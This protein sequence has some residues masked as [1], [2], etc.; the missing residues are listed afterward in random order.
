MSHAGLVD[1]FLRVFELSRVIPGE[2]AAIVTDGPTPGPYVEIAHD[3]F[4][5]MGIP[6]FHLDLTGTAD[7]DESIGAAATVGD[8][9]SAHPGVIAALRGCDFVLDLLTTR[10]GGLIHDRSRGLVADSGTR[11]LH[12]NEP[13]E[14]LLR[15]V[16]TVG[17]RDQ[18]LRAAQRLREGRELH[19]S[20]ATGTDLSVD[21]TGS[22]VNA[23]YGYADQPGQAASWPGGFVAGYPVTG[24]AAGRVVLSPGDL[25]L[26]TMRYVESTVTLHWED[27][28]ITAIE[29][30]GFDAAVLRDYF[31]YWGEPNAYGLSHLGWG[32]NHDAYWWAMALQEPVVGE[33]TE[34]RSFAGSFMISTGVNRPAGRF[35]RC[36]FDLPMR[37]C[38]V[39]LDGVEVVRG[40]V[41]AADPAAAVVVE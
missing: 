37:N 5:R 36:H 33:F 35:T 34:G 2:T 26:T 25:N 31:A 14:T 24:T 10:L 41:L 19:V 4:A 13:P 39:V 18:A 28:H 38:T 30:D 12:V 16:P 27:D 6:A 20:S 11:M 9:L 40:G 32:I 22:S 17:L 21:M 23:F 3:A 8:L 1:A 7:G 15:H 29:G